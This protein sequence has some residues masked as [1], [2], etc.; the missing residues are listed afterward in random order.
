MK[1]PY[2]GLAQRVP[3]LK[4]RTRELL[5]FMANI[6]DDRGMFYMSRA[7]TAHEL[8]IH[9]DTIKASLRELIALGYV[10]EAQPAQPGKSA[11]RIR[12]LPDRWPGPP[13]FRA[14]ESDDADGQP[15]LAD[16]DG[17]PDLSWPESAADPAPASARVREAAAARARQAI[18]QPTA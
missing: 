2:I 1:P 10:M 16:A 18:R 14:A 17:A 5:A 7:R 6:A 15:V 3:G 9:P 4:P 11:R 8:S 13:E 12:L